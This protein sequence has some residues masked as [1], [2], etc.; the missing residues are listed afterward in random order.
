M[1][2]KDYALYKDR[3]VRSIISVAFGRYS[4]TFRPVFRQTWPMALAFALFW[5]ALS[6]V[7]L[8]DAPTWVAPIIFVL[9]GIVELYFYSIAV[10]HLSSHQH[11]TFKHAIILLGRWLAKVF[12]TW[13]QYGLSITVMLLSLLF[14]LIALLVI[15]LPQFVM[16][17]AS[18]NS[19][20][21]V[22]QG[23][24]AGLPT[25]FIWMASITFYLGGI[26]RAYIGL[27][28]VYCAWYLYGT[29]VARV[30]HVRKD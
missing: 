6:L 28:V 2:E 20:A 10:R 4:S 24:P 17:L 22:L 7:P 16:L 8:L 5:M 29:I 21:G 3:S 25:G 27:T 30:N 14:F 13:K 18:I 19:N 11:L 12:G 15:T 26:L 23:D 1:M 9:G